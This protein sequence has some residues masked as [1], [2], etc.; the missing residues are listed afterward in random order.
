M[1]TYKVLQDIEAEDK[2]LGPLTL[3]QFIFG[4]IAVVSSYLSFIFITKDIW[5]MAIPMFPVIIVT[6]FLAF[7]WGRDQPTETW[8]LAKIRFYF[9]PRK[10]VWDQTGM[11]ELVKITA[12][13]KI[14]EYLSDNLSQVEVK[15]RLKALADTI[16]SRGWA[17][18][19][20][21]VNMS[22]GNAPYAVPS[23]AQGSDRLVD[24]STLPQVGSPAV[25]VSETDDIFENSRANQVASAIAQ[26]DKQRR[27]NTVG[28]LQDIVDN[29]ANPKQQASPDYWFM[30]E[31]EPPKNGMA[32]FGTR[33]VQPSS[34]ND[35]LSQSFSGRPQVSSDDQAIL[36]EIHAKKGGANSGFRNHKTVIPENEKS[37]QNSTAPSV[38]LAP[39]PVT[40]R[41]AGN[42]DRVVSSLAK[43]SNKA[44]PKM[45]DDEVIISLH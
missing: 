32:M 9:K 29:D 2:F 37:A 43:E 34:D 26:S 41:L 28:K 30:N 13:P 19:N 14:Q 12:P 38:T 21:N 16:D 39:D 36:D 45:P 27:V 24:V 5:V 8:L 1:A 20:V 18:K 40:M 33:A 4:A 23:I 42:N 11:Q 15:S 31:P 17:V 35:L 22:A 44:H 6:G 10:R 3:K 25:D 7:P